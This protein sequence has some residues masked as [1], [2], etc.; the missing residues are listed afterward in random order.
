[1]KRERFDE[2]LGKFEED[3]ARY[4]SRGFTE[5]EFGDAVQRLV[6]SKILDA[7]TNS[8]LAWN[9]ALTEGNGVGFTA[10]TQAVERMRGIEYAEA[11]ELARE[12]FP[13]R[14]MLRLDQK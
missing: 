8:I 4:A 5:K 10:E 14:T 2:I 11:Q 13:P 1:V 7:Q 6:N 9:L 12:V 3:L